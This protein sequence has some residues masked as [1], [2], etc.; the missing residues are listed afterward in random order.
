[1]DCDMEVIW[2]EYTL[3]GFETITAPQRQEPILRRNRK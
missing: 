1:V 3:Y 2:P